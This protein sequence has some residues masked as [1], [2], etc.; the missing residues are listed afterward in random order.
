MAV[1]PFDEDLGGGDPGRTG[2]VDRPPDGVRPRGTDAA[3]GAEPVTGEDAGGSGAARAAARLVELWETTR[4][5]IRDPVPPAQLRALKVLAAEQPLTCGRLGARLRLTPSAAGRLCAR[6]EEAGLLRRGRAVG[7]R[8]RTELALT[9]AGRRT[10]LEVR[11]RRREVLRELLDGESGG[12]RDGPGVEGARGEGAQR[13]A[14]GE[15]SEL[16]GVLD[17]LRTAMIERLRE[18]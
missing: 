18:A 2:G 7:D 5:R 11:A 13:D 14:A 10:L 8:R 17:A 12:N 3:P 4:V 16:I 6:M 9:A 1:R 15:E